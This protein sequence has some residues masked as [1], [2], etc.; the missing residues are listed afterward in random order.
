MKFIFWH[1]EVQGPL[2]LESLWDGSHGFAGSVGRLRLAFWLADRGHDVLLAG[3]VREG[4]LRGVRAVSG[5]EWLRAEPGEGPGGNRAILVM[6]NPPGE[7]D[8]QQVH[9]HRQRFAVLL[10]PANPI[11]PVWLRRTQEGCPAKIVCIS[12]HHRE[13][14][15]IYP[16]FRNVE[17]SYLGTDLDLVAGAPRE[18]KEENSVLFC[19]IPRRTKGLHNLLRAWRRVRELAPEA[20]LRITGS[21]RLHDPRAEV[22]R[23][24]ILD[25]ELEAEFP[26]FFADP[27]GSLDRAGIHLLGALPSLSMVYGA[28]KAS[29]VAVV[30]CNWRGAAELF[31]RSA[32]EAQAAGTPVVGASRGSLPEVV[33]HGVTGLLVRKA[34]PSLLAEAIVRLLRDRPLRKR[35]EEACPAWALRFA[36][37]GA[38][39]RDWE[40]IA[41]RALKGERTP[42]RPAWAGDALRGIGY[43]RVRAWARDRIYGTRLE[44]R[45]LKWMAGK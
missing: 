33:S 34:D 19:S 20:R 4:S 1:H 18:A 23:T 29:A 43:G 41:L 8:W 13:F 35:M 11:R 14:Y 12:E 40:E 7:A 16:A 36:D 26:D 6:S 17:M 44:R 39:A 21:A 38:A 32:V 24:G 15:R 10:W 9:S 22:G 25:Q 37:Y 31:C 5:M 2:T 45:L 3:C 28:M 27:P 42:A 30:N